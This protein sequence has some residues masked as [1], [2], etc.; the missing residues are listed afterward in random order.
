MKMW[1]RRARTVIAMITE[2][3]LLL[4]SLVLTITGF[5]GRESRSKEKKYPMKSRDKRR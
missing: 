2:S 4:S 5:S 3:S 1:K